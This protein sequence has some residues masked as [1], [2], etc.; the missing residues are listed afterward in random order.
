M[1]KSYAC[2]TC[3]N[4][5]EWPPAHSEPAFSSSPVYF[6]RACILQVNEERRACVLEI[7]GVNKEI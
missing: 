2:I 5:K 3:K 1:V 7:F 4:T 6:C